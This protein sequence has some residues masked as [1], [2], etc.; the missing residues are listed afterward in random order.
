MATKAWA[1]A[2]TALSRAE[3]PG[4]CGLLRA[5]TLAGFIARHLKLPYCFAE[6]GA[7]LAAV[8]GAGVAFGLT[9]AG[10]SMAMSSDTVTNLKPLASRLSI[11]LGM[12]SIVAL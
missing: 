2:N 9:G 11:V 1:V 6:T 4:N 10:L 3:Q 5:A 8:F 12:A 7:A